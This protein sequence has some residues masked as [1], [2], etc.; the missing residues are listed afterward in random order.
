[1]SEEDLIKY[2]QS[3]EEINCLNIRSLVGELVP[4]YDSYGKRPLTEW[5]AHH[6]SNYDSVLE[7][8]NCKSNKT[9]Y[10]YHKKAGSLD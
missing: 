3:I 8:R 9:E 6:H 4:F 5:Y 10:F 7:R 2:W 1:M